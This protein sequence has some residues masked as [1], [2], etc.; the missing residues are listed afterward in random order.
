MNVDSKVYTEL[1]KEVK[2]GAR[3]LD[4]HLKGRTY[5]VG[6]SITLA[7]LKMASIFKYA[8]TLLFDAGYRK[9]VQN[10]TKWFTLISSHKAYVSVF[11]NVK[12]CNKAMKV[13]PYNL[14]KVVTLDVGA[15]SAIAPNTL[16]ASMESS[17]LSNFTK[18]V[19]DMVGQGVVV[20]QLK[21]EE[22]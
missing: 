15:G 4:S 20:K 13:A 21:A 22:V 3:F 17:V 14:P 6:D 11:G 1:V 10:L 16:V 9:A 19:A 2:D 5:V 8:F 7:D 18:V 12:L